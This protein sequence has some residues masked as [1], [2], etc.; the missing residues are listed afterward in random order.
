MPEP[1]LSFFL[2]QDLRDL[3]AEFVS[4]IITSSALYKV[5][6]SILQGGC[7][8]GARVATPSLSTRIFTGGG[9]RL[10]SRTRMRT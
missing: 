5:F 9:V 2:T 1:E 6:I 3:K 7:V 4:N 10:V 8:I